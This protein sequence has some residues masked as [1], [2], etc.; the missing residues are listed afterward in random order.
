LANF[1]IFAPPCIRQ[2]RGAGR[3]DEYKRLA[4]TDIKA[5]VTASDAVEGSQGTDLPPTVEPGCDYFTVE[6]I[7]KGRV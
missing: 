1:W 4:S 3:L 2:L 6:D 5:G 7:K